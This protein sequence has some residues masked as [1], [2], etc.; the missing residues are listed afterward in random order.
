MG[1]TS[2]A[3]TYVY[4]LTSLA[5]ALNIPSEGMP[6]PLYAFSGLI[7]WLVFSSGI[8]NAG[9][10][11]AIS[12]ANIIKKIYFP[13]LDHFPIPSMTSVSLFDFLMAFIVFAGMLVY[14]KK[15][16]T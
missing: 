10:T 4:F 7:L 9:N 2:A 12:N 5:K 11:H 6:Y 15:A 8:S 14:Y 1:Y 3:V 16:R 13:R